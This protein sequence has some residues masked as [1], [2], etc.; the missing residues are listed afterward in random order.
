MG[1]YQ[2]G[3]PPS[4]STCTVA[5]HRRQCSR[6]YTYNRSSVGHAGPGSADVR[7]FGGDDPPHPDPQPE[8]P[9]G[10]GPQQVELVVGQRARRTGGM[11]ATAGTATR[12]DRRCRCRRSPTGP[13]ATAP[14]ARFVAATL[15]RAP[16]TSGRRRSGS[17]PSR[18]TIRRWSSAVMSSQRVGPDRS[19]VAVDETSRRRTAPTGSGGGAGRCRNLP[20]RPRWT[21]RTRP[22]SKPQNRYFPHASARCRRGRVE[23]RRTSANRPCGE[24]ARNGPGR[25]VEFSSRARRWM[26]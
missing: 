5:P 10:V 2:I 26:V 11:D 24:D 14:M 23:E 22:E 12:P 1:Q 8:L 15:R 16:S 7:R 3:R 18:D 20:M 19:Q 21:C 25:S 4:S 9:H 17:A 13:A 6:W